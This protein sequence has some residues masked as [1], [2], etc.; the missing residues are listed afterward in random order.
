MSTTTVPDPKGYPLSVK[1]QYREV[2]KFME[3]LQWSVN[4]TATLVRAYA[5]L[6]KLAPSAEH[7]TELDAMMQEEKQQFVLLETLCRELKGAESLV[8]PSAF[9]FHTYKDGLQQAVSLERAAIRHYRDTYL[10][11]PS[12]RVR[13]LF[14]YALCDGTDHVVGLMLLQQQA[15]VGNSAILTEHV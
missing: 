10:L 8:Q 15:M 2:R 4:H 11:T 1:L 14:F 6:V 7:A 5:V 3:Q 12:P 9:D 13:D